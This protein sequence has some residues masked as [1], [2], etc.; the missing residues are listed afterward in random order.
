MVSDTSLS[1]WLLQIFVDSG[2]SE[3][4]MSSKIILSTQHTSL[5]GL[6]TVGD[7]ATAS[8]DGRDQWGPGPALMCSQPKI[9]KV[10]C[11][12]ILYT[13]KYWNDLIL[14]SICQ[15]PNCSNCFIQCHYVSKRQDQQ[16]R[17][18][19]EVSEQQ[20]TWVLAL[21]SEWGKVKPHVEE[22]CTIYVLVWLEVFVLE[23]NL[24]KILEDTEGN[25]RSDSILDFILFSQLYILF[26]SL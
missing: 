2:G 17:D 4:V 9:L 26:F 22:R 19:T 12:Y 6:M 24:N 8:F 3:S 23:M 25:I 13:I 1:H 21:S 7:Q 5:F 15:L 14:T 18:N 20:E 11:F 10:V 16:V